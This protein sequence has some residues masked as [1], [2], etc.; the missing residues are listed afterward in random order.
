M[1]LQKFP[2]RGPILSAADE[3]ARRP[4]ATVPAHH[5]D[6]GD[7]EI[8]DDGDEATIELGRFTHVHFGCYEK[9]L[10]EIHKFQNIAEDVTLFLSDVFADKVQFY[11]SGRS[12]GFG[13]VGTN[14]SR[15]SL[16]VGILHDYFV[17]SG[18]LKPS[19]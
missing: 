1:L 7:I 15:I 11:A 2:E 18:P 13:P 19:A 10:A 17:W 9:E 8:Y 14:Q 5:G 6:F 12:G 3:T 16:M 4:F